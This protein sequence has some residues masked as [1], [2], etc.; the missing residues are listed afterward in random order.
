MLRRG[1]LG[2]LTRGVPDLVRRVRVRI[3]TTYWGLQLPPAARR[4][5]ARRSE[6]PN[7]QGRH[8]NNVIS[9]DFDFWFEMPEFENLDWAF[10]EAPI[11]LDMI[12]A[13]RASNAI[14][15]G[16]DLRKICRIPDDEPR[17][18][19]FAN[20]LKE[21]KLRTGRTKVAISES[22]LLA[23]KWFNDLDD[24]HIIH[25]DAHHDLGGYRGGDDK[26]DCGNWL[27]FLVD[28]GKVSKLTIIYPKWRQRQL[29][30]WKSGG[31]EIREGIKI[32]LDV[33]YGLEHLPHNLTIKKILLARSGAWVPPWLDR[34]F[35]SLA[36]SLNPS[37]MY[38]WDDLMS[39]VRVL[40]WPA[41]EKSGNEMRVMMEKSG[42]KS[43]CA[44]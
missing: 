19:E 31:D 37:M 22:H 14:A 3:A 11:F 36:L 1:A 44:M 27:K 28:E 23:Y 7:P 8:M 34:D 15:V 32:P 26:I 16:K 20:L 24:L 17:P 39:V 6:R 38:G 35:M 25:I 4:S 18:R 30:E 13:I 5:T 12:W 42:I 29:D 21:H 9:L 2:I 43:L 40:D 33:H 10:G 41:I